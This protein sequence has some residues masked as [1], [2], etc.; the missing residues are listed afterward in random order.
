MSKLV[1]LAVLVSTLRVMDTAPAPPPTPFGMAPRLLHAWGS[2]GEGEG[3][4]IYVADLAV[5]R[6]GD[7]YALD[8]NRSLIRK[9]DSSGT[10]L[11]EW[12]SRGDGSGQ[13]RN[14]VALG[15]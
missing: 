9:Y 5:D 2:Y 4:F 11:L 14:P 6:R 12:G 7:V 10:I 1:V 13:F 15:V 3:Q 8:P